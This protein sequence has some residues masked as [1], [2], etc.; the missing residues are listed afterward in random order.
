[1]GANMNF[2]SR[3]AATAISCLSVFGAG[4]V[5]SYTDGGGSDFIVDAP[6]RTIRDYLPVLYFAPDIR[7]QGVSS[8]ELSMFD[9][10]TGQEGAKIFSDSLVGADKLSC[11]GLGESHDIELIDDLGVVR[12]PLSTGEVD[13]HWHYV[14]RIPTACIGSPGLVGQP[15]LKFLQGKIVTTGGEEITKVLRVVVHPDEGLATFHRSDQQFDAHFHTIAEQTAGNVFN[16][17][18]GLKAFGGPLVMMIEAGYAIGMLDRKMENGNWSEFKN[19]VATTDHNAFHSS[20]PFDL[21][22]SPQFGP[23]KDKANG[24][25]EFQWYRDNLGELAGEEVTLNGTGPNIASGL[26]DYGSHMLTFGAPHFHGPWHGGGI[27]VEEVVKPYLKPHSNLPVVDL[28]ALSLLEALESVEDGMENPWGVEAAL[29]HAGSTD[30]FS[31]AAHP[32]SGVGGWSTTYFDL[33]LGHSTFG[34]TTSNSVQVNRSGTDFVFKGSQVWNGKSEFVTDGRFSTHHLDDLNP[35]GSNSTV[36]FVS[37]ASTFARTSIGSVPLSEENPQN[38]HWLRG[39]LRPFESYLDQ[40]SKGLRFEFSD[41]PGL[42]FPRKAYM[43]AGTDAHGDFNFETSIP[44]AVIPEVFEN[45]SV[46]GTTMQEATGVAGLS[47][48]SASSNAFGRVRTYV[49]N[50]DADTAPGEDLSIGLHLEAEETLGVFDAGIGHTV[51]SVG[52]DAFENGI[53]VLTDGPICKFHVDANCR[54]NSEVG[55]SSWHDR[56]CIFENADGA[57]GGSGI[58]DGGRTALVPRALDI[59]REQ[60]AIQTM[61]KGRNDYIYKLNDPSRMQLGLISRG[62]GFDRR[63]DLQTG[64]EGQPTVTIDQGMLASNRLFDPSALVLR[65]LRGEGIET[66]MCLTNPIWTVPYKIRIDAPE[67]CPIA[68]GALEVT[69]TFGTSMD[70]TISEPSCTDCFTDGTVSYLGA[71]IGVVSLNAQGNSTGNIK[72]LTRDQWR[73][74]NFVTGNGSINNAVLKATNSSAISCTNQGWDSFSHRPNRGLN[75]YAVVVQDIHDTNLNRLNNI[76]QAFS[77]RTVFHNDNEAPIVGPA[78]PIGRV[79]PPNSDTTG[80]GAIQTNPSTVTTDE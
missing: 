47:I 58:F 70:P 26:A 67:R 61:W 42:R 18:V 3:C 79:T 9:I 66:S 36:E 80:S 10:G 5:A 38:G 75:S 73:P 68:A 39:V 24:I 2:T 63:V 35:F 64:L 29:S 59:D 37:H 34:T 12:S 16:I 13:D 15:G 49:L 21:G 51:S 7:K 19:L 48:V 52:P 44:A 62:P 45:F 8:F 74:L 41:K 17:D 22:G 43:V 33:L 27:K 25:E 20:P 30:G 40:V 50:H 1:M 65:G 32:F 28:L 23:T 72:Y 57:I 53:S 71:Q 56:D 60:V 4:P 14:A 31:Y 76:G 69:V 11:N 77:V 78:A 6:W 55:E 46:G 54:F